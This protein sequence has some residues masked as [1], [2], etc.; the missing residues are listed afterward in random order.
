MKQDAAQTAVRIAQSMIDHST[1][2][3][4]GCKKLVGPLAG[5]G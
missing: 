3:L 1:P 5:R 2:L 4:L